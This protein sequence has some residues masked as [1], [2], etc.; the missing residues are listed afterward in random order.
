MAF[1]FACENFLDVTSAAEFFELGIEL[2][3][4]L[5]NSNEIEIDSEEDVFNAVE[6]WIKLD[7]MEREAFASSLIA[8]LRMS[9]I[10]YWVNSILTFKLFI[11][12]TKNYFYYFLFVLS[13]SKE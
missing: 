6:K 12:E 7:V 5:L 4:D 2:L 10:S 3:L 9:D 8:T 1:D 11:N 13:V